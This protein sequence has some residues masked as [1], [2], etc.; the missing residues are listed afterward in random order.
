MP[1]EIVKTPLRLFQGDPVL[2]VSDG[3]ANQWTDIWTYQVPVGVILILEP[4][5][6]F[7][8]YLE[9]ATTVVGDATCQVKIEKR[10]SSGSD[11]LLIYGA[12]L[13]L[14]SKEFQDKTKMAKLRVPADGISVEQREKLVISVKDD[15]AIDESDSYFELR[16]AKIRKALG[17]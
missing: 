8:A 2:S 3:T 11:V 13:Y 9:D 7:S 17:V 16:I 10:D 14:T 12:E 5:A 15:G 4:T 6:T 1:P